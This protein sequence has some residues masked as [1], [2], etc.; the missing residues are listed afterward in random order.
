MST[1]DLFALLPLLLIAASAVVVMLGIAFKRNPRLAA[2]LTIAGLTAAFL[3][4]WAA[5]GVVPRQVTP[6][7]LVDRYAL[8]YMSLI[9]ASAA[10]AA[11][12]AYHYFEKH[13]GQREELYL[14]LLLATLGCAVLAASSH[15]VSFLLGLEVLSV[16]LYGMVAYLTDRRRALEAGIKYL[17]LASASAAFLLFGMALIYAATGAMEFSKLRDVSLSGSP[18]LLLSGI[19][20]TI[21][22]IGF[23]LGVVPF[24]LWTPDVYQGASPPVAAFVA[25]TSKSAMVAL[26]LRYFY[27]SGALRNHAVFLVVATIAV[28]SMCAGNFLALRQTNVKRILAYSSIAH[29]GYIL[30]ALLAGSAMAIGAVA[31]YLVAYTVTLLAAFGVVA[32][33]SNSGRDAEDVE[34]YRG[35]FWRR[36]AIA[37]VFTVAL[38]SLAG[39]PAT[40][41]F[42]GKFYI[43][44]AG[45]NAA[46]WLLI[47]I[48]VVTSVAGL[49][50]YL[51]IVVALFTDPPEHAAPLEVLPRGVALVLA[52]LAVLTIW[53]G[54]YPSPLLDLIRA[55]LVGLN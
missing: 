31:F 7:L 38:L 54:V 37:G 39:I 46:A 40:M 51:R 32:I 52:V 17:I 27:L 42:L 43:L 23:K 4:A 6:L 22:G 53:I 5:A 25:T 30:V 35:L 45:A 24:H 8:F 11:V 28:L 36:P 10:V 55:S 21:T 50:Y 49:F 44:A 29:F 33:L 47:L 20:L 2:G 41:G 15:F 19:V 34:D 48:L 26:L 1:R 12:L 14:L 13:D 16:S 18:L 9:V 3:S